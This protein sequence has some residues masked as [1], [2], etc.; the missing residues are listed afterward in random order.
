MAALGPF[1]AKVAT[2]PRLADADRHGPAI[3]AEAEFLDQGG[4][5]MGAVHGFGRGIEMAG[6]ADFGVADQVNGLDISIAF[7]VPGGEKVSKF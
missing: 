3:G 7:V 4:V 2:R 1:L 5:G 6:H